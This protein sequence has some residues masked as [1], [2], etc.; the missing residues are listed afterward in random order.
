MNT[1]VLG[2]PPPPSNL[3]EALAVFQADPPILKKDKAGH[4]SKY[5]DLVQVNT[6]VLAR[7]N[8]LGVVW[9]TKPT[10]LDDG[11][12]V[13]VYELL[14]VP[15]GTR[16]TG[17]WPLKLSDNPQQMGSAVTYGRRYALLAVTG[18]AAEDEDDDGQG[19]VGRRPAQRAATRQAARPAPAAEGQVTQRLMRQH[20]TRPALPGESADD[21]ADDVQVRH[22][23]ALWRDLGMGGED[24]RTRRLELMCEW[25]G[26]ESLDTSK[27]LTRGQV[28]TVIKQ[29]AAKREQVR[30]PAPA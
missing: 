25:L 11:K 10:L 5:A 16:E 14:H 24:K 22:M 20:T 3:D 1:P 18:V 4:Q 8:A 21:P 17:T 7:L 2:P 9:K 29:L 23:Y 15:S 19:A 26:L 30:E 13:L 12:F 27:G 6:V 28:A